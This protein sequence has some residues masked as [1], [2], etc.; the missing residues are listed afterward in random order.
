MGF[1][2]IALDRNGTARQSVAGRAGALAALR[3]ENPGKDLFFVPEQQDDLTVAA[4]A[5][6]ILSAN[7]DMLSA[8]EPPAGV[9]PDALMTSATKSAAE[10]SR[11]F[12]VVYRSG[13]V[14]YECWQGTG[15]GGR[16]A[17]CTIE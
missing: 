1:T 6:A 5:S 8:V 2:W 3:R 16:W 13:R 12:K 7:S 10:A 9:A 14:A 17:A 15:A 11:C 4:M